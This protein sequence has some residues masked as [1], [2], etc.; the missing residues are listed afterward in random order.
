MALDRLRLFVDY[1]NC[2][3]GA[4]RT[5]DL[6]NSSHWRGQPAPLLLG[7]AIA[8]RQ[9]NYEGAQLRTLE[10]VHVFRGMPIASRDPVGHAAVRRQTAQ[11]N[12]SGGVVLH[13]RPL[14][15]R[16]PKPREKGVDVE[17]AV[18]LVAGAMDD[19]FDVAVVFSADTDLLPALELAGRIKSVE[20]ACWRGEGNWQELRGEG[21]RYAHRLDQRAFDQVEDQ[22]DYSAKK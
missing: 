22:R 18:R 19:E 4:R 16:G 21:I 6:E 12:S 8:A 5:F 17:L 14:N 7:K 20:V 3:R 2:Y 11:W 10:E 15:Y 9:P 1:Q 13:S